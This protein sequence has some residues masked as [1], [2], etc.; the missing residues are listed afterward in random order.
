MATK[1]GWQHAVTLV[2]EQRSD[3]GTAIATHLGARVDQVSFDAWKSTG[4][5][6]EVPFYTVAGPEARLRFAGL[7]AIVRQSL[8][9]TGGFGD[10]SWDASTDD[11][12]PRFAQTGSGA[13]GERSMCEWLLH[14]GTV[15]LPVPALGAS[16]FEQFLRLSHS[17]EM[18][19]WR[20]EGDYDRPIP[21][22]LVDER[23]VPADAFADT[24]LASAW[25]RGPLDF[26]EE[27]RA[28]FDGWLASHPL[29]LRKAADRI[30][31]SPTERAFQFARR[32]ARHSKTT[33]RL[34]HFRKLHPSWPT[35][36]LFH[37]AHDRIGDRYPAAEFD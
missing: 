35:G 2:D 33:G 21:R 7:G 11:V 20:E 6:P 25:L 15:S 30:V 28:D 12:G 17:P 3:D 24:K 13:P 9:T 5:L 1:A 19:P 22:R 27:T 16:D 14:T 32:V 37:W 36:R 8:M 23:G 18:A 10:A 31:S 26:C 34:R 4:P 29:P